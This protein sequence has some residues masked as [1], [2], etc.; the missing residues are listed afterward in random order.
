MGEHRYPRGQLNPTDEGELR[1]AMAIK[2]NT[3]VIDF[4]KP[5]AWIG[6]GLHEVTALRER[7]EEYERILKALAP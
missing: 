7:F 1:I 4:G 6:L 3:L 5:V 2:G